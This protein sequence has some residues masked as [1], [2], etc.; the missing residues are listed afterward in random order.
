MV[1]VTEIT[2][3][4]VDR[5]AAFLKR[6][7][8]LS[9]R[10]TLEQWARSVVPP[11]KMEA[12]NHGFMLLDGDEVVGVYVALYA[13]RAIGAS[14]HRLCSLCAWVVEPSHRL[15]SLKLM[16]ALL[17]Q[18]GLTF[19]DFSPVTSVQRVNARFGFEYLDTTMSMLPNLPWASWKG[20]AHSDV[21]EIRRLLSGD[22]LQIFEDHLETA[23]ARHVVLSRGSEHCY[24]MYRHQTF[25]KIP[26]AAI[27]HVSDPTVFRRTHRLFGRHVLFNDGRWA[28]LVEHRLVDG[29]MP[30]SLVHEGE[31]RKMYKSDTLTANEIDYL[32][33]ELAVLEW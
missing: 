9:P 19:T 15:H 12:P 33:S 22:Q 14:T 30:L 8:E 13:D 25:R 29:R 5:V 17:D 1:T 6:Q 16:K 23:A 31:P 10:V 2:G 26:C 24:V 7:P 4:D 28:T 3:A 27:L 21:E 18:D 32:Y 20:R 11:W